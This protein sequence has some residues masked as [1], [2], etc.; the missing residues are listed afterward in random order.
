VGVLMS[1]RKNAVFIILGQSNAV[2]HKIPMQE[3]DKILLPLNNV[4]G[5]SRKDNQSFNN[6][7]LIWSGYTSFGMNLAEEQDNTYSVPNCLASIWQNHIDNGNKLKLPDLYIVQIAIGA[8]GVRE[9]SMSNPD[10]KEILIPGK[11]GE[12][13]ISLFP[14][15]KHILSLLDDSF[16][17]QNKEYEIIGLHWRGGEGEANAEQEYLF[18]NLESIYKKIF[19]D[20][21]V[22]LNE[23]PIVLHK[24]VCYD[25]V[26]RRDP[27]GGRLQKIHY[28]NEV[29]SRFEKNYGN[30]TI[31]DPTK[32]PQYDPNIFGNGIFIEDAIHFTPEV[33]NW[34]AKCIFEKYCDN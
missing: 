31:F 20:F 22:I 26:Q 3:Q 5:L 2:G 10:R 27:T 7:N 32:A 19:D 28:I 15:S 24:I 17:K 9:G 34:V 29:F 33:N 8:Q 12:V 13:D 30:V 18:Q 11:L 4:F 21:N 6:T 25:H 16:K 23:P 14:F 1:N